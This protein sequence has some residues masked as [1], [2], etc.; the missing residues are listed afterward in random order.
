[1]KSKWSVG[2]PPR[3]FVWVMK[4]TLALGERPGGYET[5]HRAV[6][7]HEELLWLRK[8]GFTRVVSLAS[9]LHDFDPYEQVG[10]RWASFPISSPS[11]LQKV[12]LQIYGYLDSWVQ[13]RERILVHDEQLDDQVMG[14]VAGYLLWSGKLASPPQAI[15]I[16]ERLVQKQMGSLGRMV[17][18]RVPINTK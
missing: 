11:H 8:N 16:M 1:M 7:R 18:S 9:S 5:N 10:L 15:M 6:R 4:N 14:V 17:V 3:N 12:L 2:I 13:Q